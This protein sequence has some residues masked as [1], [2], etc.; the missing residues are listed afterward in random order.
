MIQSHKSWRE[1]ELAVIFEADGFRTG[2]SGKS[3]SRGT[4]LRF[5]GGAFS[6]DDFDSD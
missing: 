1:A 4:D 6:G 3:G 5:F 2:V